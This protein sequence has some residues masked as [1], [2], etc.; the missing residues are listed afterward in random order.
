MLHQRMPVHS[1]AW[2]PCGVCAMTVHCLCLPAAVAPRYEH[3]LGC[4]HLAE[5]CLLHLAAGG[6]EDVRQVDVEL[7][8]LAGQSHTCTPALPGAVCM[9]NT[10]SACT[11]LQGCADAASSSCTQCTLSSTTHSMLE[12]STPHVPALPSVHQKKPSSAE[13]IKALANPGC[14][15]GVA[16]KDTPLFLC[17]QGCAMTWATDPSATPLTPSFTPYWAPNTTG[18]QQ[19]R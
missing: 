12:A 14:I 9:P 16:N 15:H 7:T 3:S 4:A 8:A 6:T 1:T 17:T 10:L 18:E 11:W 19:P 5:R 2:Q 13:A